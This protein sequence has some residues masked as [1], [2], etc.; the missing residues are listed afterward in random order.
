MSRQVLTS[1]SPT[2]ATMKGNPMMRFLS[3]MC[4]TFFGATAS[5]QVGAVL[6]DA[7]PIDPI[8]GLVEA[9]AS[10]GVVA[11]DEGVG[12]GHEQ[13]HAFLR[14]LVDDPRLAGIVDDIVV[15]WGN[16]LF[17]DVIDK[18][19]SGEEVSFSELRQV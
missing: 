11:I 17:Q 3:L 18:Y 8:E 10:H 12:H 2:V 14:A 13:G 5:A 7:V 1:F 4:L 16:S 15:E 6:R 9:F 19:T